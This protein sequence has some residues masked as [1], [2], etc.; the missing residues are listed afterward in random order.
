MS[1]TG[2]VFSILGCIFLII[3]LYM[4]FSSKVSFFLRSES[5]IWAMFEWYALAVICF[6]VAAATTAPV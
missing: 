5:K 2:T 1:P 6:I 3:A 4:C